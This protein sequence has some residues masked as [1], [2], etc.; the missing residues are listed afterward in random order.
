MRNN[1]TYNEP[2]RIRK[3][4]LVLLVIGLALLLLAAGAYY[5]S[6]RD[7]R[8]PGYTANQ[9]ATPEYKPAKSKAE[10]IRLTATGD[11]LPHGS[12]N[13]HAKTGDSY[14]YRKY[15][16]NVE[17]VLK[18]SD[19][20][21]CN[22]EAP[23]AASLPVTSYPVF[24]APPEFSKDLN[25]I[26]CNLINLS[27]NHSYDK[28]QAGIEGTLDTWDRLDILAKAGI[29]RS[30]PEQEKIAYF[31]KNGVKFAFLSYTICSNNPVKNSYAV[32]MLDRS[33]TER[34][35]PEARKNSD[36]VIVGAHWC[37]EDISREDAKQREWGTY[38]ASKGVD[39]VVG[40]GP[41]YLQPVQKLPKDG[42][43]DT[44]VWYSLGNFLS[45]QLDIN[46]LVGGIAVMDISIA[47]KKLESFS[48]APTYMHYEWTPAQKA[49]EDLLARNN[50]MIYPLHE[51]DGP[52]KKSLHG[53]NMGEQI[54]RVTQL[55]NTHVQTP[56]VTIKAASER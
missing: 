2:R 45:T 43:G 48:F 49:R 1:T 31:E 18:A 30:A 4:P 56:I 14:D 3:K 27:N 19:I 47:D 36:V 6:K 25:A 39:V 10:F 26:G 54:N 41:H 55:M 29:N 17:Q 46:G 42:G 8:G 35:L 20:N 50:L 33:L 28:G 34:Q 7:N 24:N 44:I 53:T 12:V 21:F 52:L 22:Q 5:I 15:F 11:L 40:T 13:K 16:K 23:S 38:F 32:N 37:V 51:A 9:S